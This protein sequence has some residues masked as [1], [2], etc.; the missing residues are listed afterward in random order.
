M[1]RKSNKI[2]TILVSLIVFAVVIAV[3][4]LSA[5]FSFRSDAG[6]RLSHSAQLKQ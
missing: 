4:Y 5:M 1:S 6:T 3:T 2:V